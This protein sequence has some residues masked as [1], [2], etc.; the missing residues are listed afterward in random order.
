M[1]FSI[2]LP[3]LATAELVVGEAEPFDEDAA[4]VGFVDFASSA[5]AE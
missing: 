1:R 3:L 2:L 4:V 5:W